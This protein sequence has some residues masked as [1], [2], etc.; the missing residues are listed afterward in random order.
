MRELL[1]EMSDGALIACG[2][3][4]VLIVYG[5]AKAIAGRL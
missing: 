2:I 1:L 5:I 3:A 4:G